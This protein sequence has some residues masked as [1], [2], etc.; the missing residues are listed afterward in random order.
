MVA[1]EKRA[2]ICRCVAV[3]VAVDKRHGANIDV[4]ASSLHRNDKIVK[5][6]TPSGLGAM[7]WFYVVGHVMKVIAYFTDSI[8]LVDVTVLQVQRCS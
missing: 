5:A 2:H 8:V 3:D 4:D 7:V 1:C 6:S